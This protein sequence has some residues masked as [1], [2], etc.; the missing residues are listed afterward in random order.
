MDVKPSMWKAKFSNHKKR[1]LE[2]IFK[3]LE[4][5]KFTLSLNYKKKIDTLNCTERKDFCEQE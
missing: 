5:E 2:S 1:I 4:V 3:I